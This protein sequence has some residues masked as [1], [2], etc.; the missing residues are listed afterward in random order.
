MLSILVA[1]HKGGSGKTTIASNLATAFASGGLRTTLADAD[2][3]RNSLAWLASR[4][5]DAAPIVGVDWVR[6]VGEIPKKTDRLVIDSPAAM[7]MRRVDRLI[8]MADV[9]LV[10]VAPSV[11]DQ[12]TT[13]AFLDRLHRLKPIRKQRRAVAVVRN[14]VRARTRATEQLDNFVQELS[15]EAIGRLPDRAIFPDLAMRGLGV[16]DLGGK[17]METV[18]EDWRALVDFIEGA[19]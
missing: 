13:V 15:V 8:R 11:F 4:P 19:D 18:V 14:R 2:R 16:F 7:K 6:Q 3:Q 17:R 9:I 12:A 1:N 10:P 5:A